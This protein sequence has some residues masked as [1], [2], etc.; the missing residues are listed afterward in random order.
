MARLQ[1]PGA[2][3]VYDFGE[4]GGEL[5]LAMERLHGETLDDATF[6]E[7]P[8]P[9]PVAVDVVAQVLE[10][11]EAAHALGIVHRDLKPANI[12]L[13]GE[14]SAP[15]VK[16]L[17]FG[18]AQLMEG[19]PQPRITA[20]GMVHG[21]PAYMSPEQCRGEP[22]DGRSDLYSLG[23]VLHELI[24]GQPPFARGVP[25]AEMMSGHLYRPPP[26]MRQLRPQLEIPSGPGG[27]GAGVPGEGEGAASGERPGD[28]PAAAPDARGVQPRSPRPREARA[29]R[30]SARCPRPRPPQDLEVP[31][32][33][34]V[35]VLEAGRPLHSHGASTAL[36]AVGFQ[37][38]P[39][40]EG[41]AAGRRPRSGHRPSAGKRRTGAGARSW[42]PTLMRRQCCCAV[43]TISR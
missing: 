43:R 13:I 28:A 38:V 23:C 22:L 9:I 1:H 31:S 34:P 25:V 4:D 32:E 12:M 33:L 39:W 27:S 5:F 6:R 19:W 36:A 17:D 14:L 8:L 30:R 20:A 10:V 29:R 11:L 7:G 37:V 40:S 2:A 3:H 35:G 16:V 24:I 21:T 15:R 18:L 41:V 26:P 42:P